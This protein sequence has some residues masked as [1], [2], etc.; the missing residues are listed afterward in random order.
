VQEQL[1]NQLPT[2]VG[3]SRAVDYIRRLVSR[4]K[5]LAGVGVRGEVS[6][7]SR[8]PSGRTYFDLKEGADVLKCVLWADDAAKLPRFKDGDEI[9]AGGEF[10][11]F[12][13][14]SQYQLFVKSVQLTGIGVLYAEFEKLKERFARE[15]LFEPSR[16]RAMPPFPR[17]IAL[18][19]A[20]G[21]GA[22]DFLTTIARRAPFIR[23]EFVETR[24]QGD[25]AQIEI[26]EA[27]DRASKLDVD[28]IVVTRGGGSYEDLFPFNLEPVVRA[29]VRASHPVLSAI[30]HTPDLHLSDLAADWSCETPSNAAQYFGEL[31]DRFSN[32]IALARSRLQQALRSVLAARAQ[33]FD[34]AVASLDR[35]L[36]DAMLAR[37]RSLQRLTQRLD[38]QSPHRPVLQ[39][40]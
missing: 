16:K 22:E 7:L 15:G 36:R 35:A 25:G 1:F 13:A 17:R 27:I 33:R 6:G 20:R 8:Q 23:V 34:Y 39:R 40:R 37:E 4:S 24:L 26:A 38:M 29:I 12:A 3:V 21:R 32:R 18:V 28:L 2:V 14:R 10:G 11:T 9:I 5:A 31:A 19:S 30:G